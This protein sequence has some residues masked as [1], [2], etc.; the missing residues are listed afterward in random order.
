MTQEQI[1]NSRMTKSA[2]MRLLFDL[3][4]NRNQVSELLNVGYGFTFNVHKKWKEARANTGI[5][6]TLSTFNFNHTFGVEIEAFGVS[7]Q[8][9]ETE[10]ANAGI[11]I[12]TESYNH[13]TRDNWKIVTDASIRGEQGFEIVSP[14]LQGENGLRQL[15]TVLL[16]TRGLEAKTNKS[17]GIHIH[18][19][20]TEFNLTTWKNLYKNYA[21]LENYIDGFMPQSRRQSNNHYCQT[22]RQANY[23]TRIDNARDLRQIESEINSLLFDYNSKLSNLTP[24]KIFHINKEAPKEEWKDKIINQSNHT[25]VIV[26]KEYEKK[27]KNKG[28]EDIL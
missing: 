9:L 20:A 10:L 28:F 27:A 22:M 7:R 25:V 16:I 11:N 18:F 21:N 17:C 14:K 24:N 12:R 8:E 2:K 23:K 4:L 26:S 6:Q 15:K 3:G 5:V 1:L 19:D 13:Q